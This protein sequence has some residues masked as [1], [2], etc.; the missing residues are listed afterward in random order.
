VRVVL[1]HPQVGA[2]EGCLHGMHTEH[3]H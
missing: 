2:A 3:L 1:R